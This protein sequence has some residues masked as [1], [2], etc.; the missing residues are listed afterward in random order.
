MQIEYL[1]QY[2]PIWEL[3]SDDEENDRTW[4]FKYKQYLKTTSKRKKLHFK[5]NDKFDLT[6]ALENSKKQQWTIDYKFKLI[7]A[8]NTKYHLIT[9]HQQNRTQKRMRLGKL[10]F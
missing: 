2:F 9:A 7:K 5:K 1:Q 3:I 6:V 10:Q 4:D 8:I